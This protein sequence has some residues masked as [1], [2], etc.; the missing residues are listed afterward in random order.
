MDKQQTQKPDPVVKG[1]VYVP[2]E[3]KIQKLYNIF[4]SASPSDVVRGLVQYVLIPDAKYTMNNMWRKAG[5]MM[6][7]GIE[8]GRGRSSDRRGGNRRH[9]Y[10]SHSR[11]D[12]RVAFQNESSSVKASVRADSWKTI[13]FDL[14]S[15]CEDIIV[16]LQED[17]TDYDQATV[18]R[19]LEL[20]GFD[21][22]PIHFEWGWENLDEADC[23]IGRN[24]RWR[25]LMPRMVRLKG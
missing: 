9:D 3:S 6:S 13:E 20:A 10:T 16:E 5:D 2:K 12:N 11:K 1:K 24:G 7:Y 4:F 23:E 17:I 25:L 21:P 8:E 18:A 14:K 19:L 15:D 22:E